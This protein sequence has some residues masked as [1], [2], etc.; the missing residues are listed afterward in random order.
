MENIEEMDGKILSRVIVQIAG[1]PEGHVVKSM[2]LL[3]KKIKNDKNF[4]VKEVDV[5]EIKEE[6]EVFNLFSEI[7][8]ETK[9]LDQLA[10][11]C[12]DYMPSSVEIEKRIKNID[13]SMLEPKS[14]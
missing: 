5:S 12:F 7:E 13:S 8:L 14:F 6:K 4:S 2:D 1:K 9:N 10:W 11:F 3:L